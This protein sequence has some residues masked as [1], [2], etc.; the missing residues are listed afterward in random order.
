MATTDT[1][2][3]IGGQ[4]FFGSSFARHLRGN[5][6]N[7]EVLTT[8]RSPTGP[9]VIRLEPSSYDQVSTV[10]R[11]TRPDVCVNFTGSRTNNLHEGVQANVLGPRI[12]AAAISDASKDCHLV[13]IG[14]AAEYGTTTKPRAIKESDALRP[15]NM[16]G[17]TK[18]MLSA[19]F[20]TIQGQ[21]GSA[22]YVRPFNLIDEE[23]PEGSLFSAVA[24]QIENQ[25]GERKPVLT[26]YLGDT[27]DF[28][29]LDAANHHLETLIRRRV[30]GRAVNLATGRGTVVRERLYHWLGKRYGT[31]LVSFELREVG[32]R[33]P[34]HSIGSIEN[35][36]SLTA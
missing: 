6:K 18:A 34:T 7:V 30:S 13:L 14:S 35:L 9:D 20:P 10:L 24:H 26:G 27:R 36:L 21:V 16:Y 23:M 33:L 15:T 29:N 22:L 4:S 12:L 31:S 3:I 8:S 28:L 2:L 17:T 25:T 32:Q 1:I 5:G 19:A 11:S